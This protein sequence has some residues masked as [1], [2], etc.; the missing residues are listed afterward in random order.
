MVSR[1]LDY[2][3]KRHLLFTPWSQFQDYSKMI[4]KLFSI[5]FM[6]FANPQKY[7]KIKFNM[8]YP[9]SPSSSPHR[10]NL[11]QPS[12]I[13]QTSKWLHSMTWKLQATE[14]SPQ[15]YYQNHPFCSSM[16]IAHNR[17]LPMLYFELQNC[18]R[19]L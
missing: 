3:S 8:N 7:K 5:I 14:F 9:G 17:S 11:W 19:R 18:P 2:P 4:R 13:T 6:R 1:L 12:A 10:Y 16:R 15:Q